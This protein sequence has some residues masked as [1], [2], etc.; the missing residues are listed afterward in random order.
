MSNYNT[1]TLK[2]LVKITLFFFILTTD[3]FPSKRQIEWTKPLQRCWEGKSILP[4]HFASDNS[5]T[6]KLSEFVLAISPSSLRSIFISS[7]KNAWE[8][9]IQGEISSE[10]IFIN[11]NIHF[12]T[13]KDSINSNDTYLNSYDVDSGLLEWRISFPSAIEILSNDS[14]IFLLSKNNELVKI[15][16]NTGEI[17]QK[18]LFEDNISLKSLF[19]ENIYVQDTQKR[20][21]QIKSNFETVSLNHKI[22]SYT[23]VFR[24]IKDSA[25][26]Y[27]ILTT[28]ENNTLTVYNKH[29]KKKIWQ[30][31]IGAK[32]SNIES[33]GNTIF[34]SSFDNF[35]YLFDLATGRLILK[36][37]LDGRITEK[38]SIQE[39]F[40]AVSANE[41]SS[42]SIFDLRKREQVNS[43]TL[44]D[45]EMFFESFI[46]HNDYLL[47]STPTKIIAFSS[48]C[49]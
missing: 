21:F 25:N 45:A 29:F 22:F 20:I 4:E 39:N 42:I 3:A 5:K 7:G 13:K 30:R 44:S 31:K 35:V 2:F 36:K 34:I 47:A 1:D 26:N 27:Y 41:S 16:S 46:L 49:Q 38:V 9:S 18:K 19:G 40:V 37:R 6:N 15:D 24:E 12:L 8:T 11:Q 33:F 43:V 32:I 17:I 14:H 23:E 28:S 48:N 10:L